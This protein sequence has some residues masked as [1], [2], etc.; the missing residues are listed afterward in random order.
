MTWIQDVFMLAIDMLNFF[1]YII[2]IV[3]KVKY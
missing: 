2:T 3:F 1:G